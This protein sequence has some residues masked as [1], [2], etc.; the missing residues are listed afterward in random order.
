MP[1]LDFLIQELRSYGGAVGPSQRVEFGM[2]GEPLEERSVLEGIED[3][4]IQFFSSRT[5][6]SPSVPSAKQRWI[7]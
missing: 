5:F 6:T 4:A 7:M 2:H 3:L 1:Q